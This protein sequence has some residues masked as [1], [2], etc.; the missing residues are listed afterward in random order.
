ML[1]NQK[2]SSFYSKL[3][4]IVNCSFYLGE[5]IPNSEVVIIIFRYLPKRF[6]SKVTV[7]EESK[8]I[9]SMRIDELVGSIQTYG[10]SFPNS[11]K[12]RDYALK[13]FENEEK[14]I[15]MSYN[16]TK[17]KLTHMAKRIKKIMKFNKKF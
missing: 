10:M 11:Q 4:N 9:D 2:I 5:P 16:T 8:D 7:I 12:P 15:E 13:T 3:S 6:M 1:E 17:D 14:Y